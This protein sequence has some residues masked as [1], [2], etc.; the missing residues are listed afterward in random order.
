[1][2]ISHRLGPS[3]PRIIPRRLDSAD[4]ARSFTLS[5]PKPVTHSQLDAKV[6]ALVAGLLGISFT[7][8][9]VP[10]S[11]RPRASIYADT[12]LNWQLMAQACARLGCP[13][14]TAYTTLGEEGLLTSL[15]EPDVE[16]VFC[17]EDQVKLVEK[18]IGRAERVK[19]VVYDASA[20]LD[21]VNPQNHC[22][23]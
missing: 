23:M 20:R 9:S 7:S 10:I 19:W 22:Q 1:M 4:N 21:Q 11:S 16:L 8:T 15:V 12:C 6:S 14:T 18:V 2:G 5:T 3:L 13:I 17:G